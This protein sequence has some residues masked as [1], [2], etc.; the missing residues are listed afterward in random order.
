[1]LK[2]AIIWFATLTIYT[3]AVAAHTL[4]CTLRVCSLCPH[5]TPRKHTSKL[6]NT[7][8]ATILHAGADQSR[9]LVRASE[10]PGCSVG[11]QKSLTAALSG[12]SGN[13]Y[14]LLSMTPVVILDVWMLSMSW[15]HCDCATVLAF[16]DDTTHV[17]A[18]AHLLLCSVLSFKISPHVCCAC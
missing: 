16:S 14:V 12:T 13:I 11:G 4:H 1:M 8:A 15:L 5:T 2:C 7:C 3:T 10:F 6:Q 17:A 9:T 18:C